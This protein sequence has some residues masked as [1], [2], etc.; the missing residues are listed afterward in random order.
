MMEPELAELLT[1][2]L[3]V[4]P[5]TGRDKYDRL[6]YGPAVSYGCRVTNKQVLVA[7]PD[8]STRTSRAY[9]IL[10]ADAAALDREDKVTLP[11]GSKPPI[12][13]ITPLNDEDGSVHHL[14]VYTG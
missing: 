11:D 3:T 7:L 8:G 10:D 14:E 6:T 9:V 13:S 2:T 4:E 12:L 1:Q 5:K